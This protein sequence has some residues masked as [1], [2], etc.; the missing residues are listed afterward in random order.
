MSEH[1]NGHHDHYH[2]HDHGGLDHLHAELDKSPIHDAAREG[3]VKE[4]ES[5]L[6]QDPALVNKVDKYGLTPLHWA[7]DHGQI[8]AV[9]LLI[10]KGADVNFVEKRLFLRQPIHFATL[11][12]NINIT[13]ILIQNGADVKCKEYR[14][15]QPIFG[16][17][18]GGYVKLMEELIAAGA[19]M[20]ATT[21]NKDTILHIAAQNQQKNVI[22]F[23][24]GE[25]KDKNWM[26]LLNNDGKRAADLTTD[27]EIHS[28]LSR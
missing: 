1:E 9:N 16:A 10:E 15:W 26:N 17:A 27:D 23:I 5:L 4:L 3:R 24:L 19:D 18:Y 12:G 28:L 6:Q 22:Q 25:E 14:G 2:K 11:N 20:R 21:S 7:C 8:D 13:K